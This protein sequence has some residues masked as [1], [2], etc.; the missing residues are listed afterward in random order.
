MLERSARAAVHSVLSRL[1]AGRLELV[2]DWSGERLA[3]GPSA[4]RLRA[5]MVLRTPQIYP[6]LL[7]G[8]SVALGETYAEEMWEVDDLLALCRMG[9]RDIGRA[10]RLR[11]RPAPVLRPIQRL[12]SRRARNT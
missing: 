11:R 3:F 5:E 6:R 9:A 4:A 1:R 8:R 12:A 7:R 2:E 10:D